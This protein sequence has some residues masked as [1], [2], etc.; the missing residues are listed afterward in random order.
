MGSIQRAVSQMCMEEVETFL[1]EAH[2]SRARDFESNRMIYRTE[3]MSTT[4]TK[5]RTKEDDQEMASA[6]ST[7]TMSR[8][9]PWSNIGNRLVGLSK[10]HHGQK[11]SSESA[12][13]SE[14]VPLA[15]TSALQSEEVP[16]ADTRH[17][18]LSRPCT[19][20]Q[21]QMSMCTGLSGTSS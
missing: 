20:T 16:V 7:L 4:G 9:D 3:P 6:S 15:G 17:Q 8:R 21:Q 11:S 2:D 10:M 1:M 19:Q 12:F 5:S 14:E 18:L 13:Q